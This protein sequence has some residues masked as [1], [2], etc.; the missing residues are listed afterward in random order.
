MERLVNN[1]AIIFAHGDSKRGP[2]EN[3][4]PLNARYILDWTIEAALE[5]SFFGIDR[6]S[7]NDAKA[8]KVTRI[9]FKSAPSSLARRVR[10]GLG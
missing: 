10:G 5:S 3:A 1:M 6:V 7:I 2:L 4:E 9:V 8:S